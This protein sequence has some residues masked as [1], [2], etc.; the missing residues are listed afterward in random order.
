MIGGVGSLIGNIFGKKSND[1][2]NKANMAI[3]KMNNEFNANEAQ[4]SR[5]YQ[6]EMWERTNE[7][8]DPSNQR[9]RNVAAG[10]NPYMSI[11]NSNAASV[12]NAPQGN[13]SSAAAMQPY[14]YSNISG[15][16]AS[17]M[18]AY[19]SSRATD[20]Q[21][22]NLQ[23]QKGLADAKAAETLANVDW[24]KLGKDGK[25]WIQATGLER[26]K[27]GIDSS[28]QALENLQW[29]NKIQRAERTQVLL[30][31]QSKTILNKYLD[32]AQQLQLD[33][34]ASGIMQSTASTHE[35]YRRAE[36]LV[37]SKIMTMAQAKG[38]KIS[39]KIAQST[40]RSYIEALRTQYASEAE[41]NK[42]S[43][44]YASGHGQL[45]YRSKRAG[46]QSSEFEYG[47]RWYNKGLQG[48]N[49]IGNQ[50]GNFMRV[51]GAKGI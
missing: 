43:L 37:A 24:W 10:L 21:I 11:D 3:N 6:T 1:N 28:R 27:L 2:A 30:D 20:A 18:Q 44:P 22:D 4:K 29:T 39:N 36:M 33:V 42:G 40:A 45:E 49:V 5:D 41:Y 26:A 35:S 17:G 15:A 48:V 19:N 34:M 31:N 16:L 32:Q 12:S 47:S 38:Q 7:Y 51:K 50:V 8:N 13:A 25:A 9:K 46:A 14:D 23:G